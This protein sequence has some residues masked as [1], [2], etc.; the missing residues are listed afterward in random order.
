MQKSRSTSTIFA[1]EKLHCQETNYN[2]H[3]QTSQWPVKNFNCG[4]KIDIEHLVFYWERSYSMSRHLV[5]LS[6]RTLTS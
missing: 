3:T 5:L 1:F 6:I 2:C 4:K